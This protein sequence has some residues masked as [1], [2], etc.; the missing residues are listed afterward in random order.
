M[1]C[2]IC[3]LGA[4][5]VLA[6][7]K[8]PKYFFQIPQWANGLI[9]KTTSEQ[10]CMSVFALHLISQLVQNI[11][12]RRYSFSGS[13]L[14]TFFQAVCMCVCVIACGIACGWPCSHALQWRAAGISGSTAL[15]GLT[16]TKALCHYRD[17]TVQ[18]HR[19]DLPLKKNAVPALLSY[20]SKV[21]WSGRFG[22][23]LA[24]WHGP[25]R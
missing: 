23:I 9:H 14:L 16:H 6:E 25:C 22:V 10:C 8:C 13:H 1:C 5:R 15:T 7:I 4:D 11:R 20:T 19:F 3:F 2:H 24:A 21:T 18:G 17:Q 12:S